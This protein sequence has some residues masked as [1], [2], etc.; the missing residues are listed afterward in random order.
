MVALALAVLGENSPSKPQVGGLARGEGA[1]M[2]V[3]L[4]VVSSPVSVDGATWCATRHSADAVR[5]DVV[6]EGGCGVGSAVGGVVSDLVED[7]GS[8]PILLDWWPDLCAWVVRRK[9]TAGICPLL[10]ATQLKRRLSG[11]SEGCLFGRGGSIGGDV[12]R[13]VV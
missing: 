10:R 1:R 3:W 4:R 13:V 12:R 7:C 6:V 5:R 8:W 11:R 9:G 2:R